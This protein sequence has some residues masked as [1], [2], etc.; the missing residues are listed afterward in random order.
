MSTRTHKEPHYG[1]AVRIIQQPIKL[2]ELFW[3]GNSSACAQ[4]NHPKLTWKECW[5][6]CT[7]TIEPQRLW[8]LQIGLVEQSSSLS[9][10]LLPPF[11]PSGR[12]LNPVTYCTTTT[13]SLN[14]QNQCRISSV[15]LTPS[16]AD[17]K[18]TLFKSLK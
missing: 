17:G 16:R 5:L 4:Y 12:V 3:H 8:R 15:I 9:P 2:C 7:F 1:K 6:V 14:P 10:L 13:R 11:H 18:Q